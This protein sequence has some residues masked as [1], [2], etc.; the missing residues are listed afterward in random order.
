M[1]LRKTTEGVRQ[2]TKELCHDRNV[3]TRYRNS[4]GFV[5]HSKLPEG[6]VSQNRCRISDIGARPKAEESKPYPP[7][8]SFR[9][10]S[11]VLILI[12]C[13]IVRICE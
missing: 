8:L 6:M 5:L 9:N 11:I 1:K 13:L 3:G 10:K 4:P 12:L 7:C 2:K